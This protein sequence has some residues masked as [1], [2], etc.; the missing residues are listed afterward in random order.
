MKIEINTELES[1]FEI[2]I[3]RLQQLPKGYSIGREV[4]RLNAM[5]VSHF[6]APEC[7]ECQNVKIL[8]CQNKLQLQ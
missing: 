2:D 7:Q 4:T 8:K 1:W 6:A 5:L 3:W